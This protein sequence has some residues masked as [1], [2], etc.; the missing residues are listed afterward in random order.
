MMKWSAEQKDT[1]KA[2]W[3]DGNSAAIIAETMGRNTSTDV[4][5]C[6]ILGIIHRAGLSNGGVPRT[7]RRAH[8]ASRQKFMGYKPTPKPKSSPM[9]HREPTAP[10]PVIEAPPISESRLLTLME[11]EFGMCKWPIGDPRTVEFRFCAADAQICRPYCASHGAMSFAPW[12][13][14][15]RA[16]G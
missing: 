8:P 11:L 16:N 2:M 14:W 1:I 12:T 5:R 13:Q 7:T 4:S 3:A 6:S 10:Q 15:R 9:A